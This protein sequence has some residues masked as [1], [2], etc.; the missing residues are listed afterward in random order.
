MY[1]VQNSCHFYH[2]EIAIISYQGE[3]NVPVNITECVHILSVDNPTE[4][5]YVKSMED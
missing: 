1:C 3:V 2:S 4:S 5:T